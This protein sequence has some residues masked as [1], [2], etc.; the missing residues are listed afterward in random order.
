MKSASVIA[1]DYRPSR[2]I[3]AAVFCLAALALAA[4]ALSGM[5]PWAK[6]GLAV[7]ACTCA[8]LGWR[9]HRRTKRF[10][11]AW[12]DAGHWRIAG[13]EGEYNA[14]LLHAVV[15]GSWIVL[16]LRRSDGEQIRCVLAPD[17]SDAHTRRRLRVRLARSQP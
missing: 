2:W 15:R 9:A 11:A 13:R 10:R 12:L 4:I 6:L 14:E 7:L 17:N 16:A 1:F 8:A 5:P 3:A